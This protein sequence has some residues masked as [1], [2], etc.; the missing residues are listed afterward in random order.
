MTDR[1]LK[2]EEVVKVEKKILS[3]LKSKFGAELRK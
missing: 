3:N 2:D 1:T